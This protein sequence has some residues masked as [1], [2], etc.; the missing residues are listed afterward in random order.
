MV[1]KTD[2]CIDRSV[3]KDLRKLTE[4]Q[5]A[6]PK[7]QR[8]MESVAQKPTV[9]SLRYQLVNDTLFFCGTGQGVGGRYYQPVWKKGPFNSPTPVYAI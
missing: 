1:N 8:I 4:L 2:L 7:L 9:P 6:D 3:C 5:K